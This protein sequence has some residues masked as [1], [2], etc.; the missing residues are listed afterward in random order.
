M[1]NSSSSLPGRHRTESLCSYRLKLT[2]RKSRKKLPIAQQAC[3]VGCV[4]R[5][6]HESAM[7][8]RVV[9]ANISVGRVR[10]FVGNAVKQEGQ[11]REEEPKTREKTRKICKNVLRNCEIIM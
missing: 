5:M 2:R 4:R 9:A 1:M 6:Y 7:W 8:R 10:G 3:R 11:T